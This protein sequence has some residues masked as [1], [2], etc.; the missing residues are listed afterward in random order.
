MRRRPRRPRRLPVPAGLQRQHLVL[1]APPRSG[2]GPSAA[3][4]RRNPDRAAA[5]ALRGPG[6]GPPPDTAKAARPARLGQQPAGCLC[7]SA[8]RGV[9]AARAATAQID[10]S[11]RSIREESPGPFCPTFPP[12][13]LG[14]ESTA[15]VAAR[16]LVA[17]TRAAACLP[18][19]G[20][21]TSPLALLA[22]RSGTATGSHQTLPGPRPAPSVRS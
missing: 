11:E 6:V 10:S 18:A 19:L 16:A 13:P 20:P 21:P 15:A 1:P 3:L 8:G 4:R 2:A 12:D 14:R 7:G 5:P 17:G 22:P 9:V